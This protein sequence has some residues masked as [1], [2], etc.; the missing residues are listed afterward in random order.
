MK[1]IVV[2]QIFIASAIGLAVLFA[3]RSVVVFAKS[4]TSLELA[5]AAASVVIAAVLSVYLRKVRAKWLQSRRS[6]PAP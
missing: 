2:H 5:L 3:I 1:L 4:G 6:M